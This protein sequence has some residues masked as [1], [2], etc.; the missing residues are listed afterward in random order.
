MLMLVG[1]TGCMSPRSA[2]DAQQRD[3]AKQWHE[4]AQDSPIPQGEPLAWPDAVNRIL[5]G[6]LEVQQAAADRRTAERSLRQVYDRLLPLVS[7][8][9]GVTESLHDLMH[10]GIRNFLSEVDMFSYFDGVMSMNQDHYAAELSYLRAATAEE[11]VRRDKI[12]ELYRAFIADQELRRAEQIMARA[13]TLQS[14]LWYSPAAAQVTSNFDD[15]REQ[16]R[17]QREQWQTDIM[18]LLQTFDHR[19]TLES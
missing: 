6:N 8:S 4:A 13:R 10:K 16:A 17:V 1:L 14:L 15:L 19:I 11:L 2:I 5:A 12:A 9:L 18:G 7:V 3:L